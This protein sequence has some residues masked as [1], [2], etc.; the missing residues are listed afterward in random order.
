[1]TLANNDISK[2]EQIVEFP[3]EQ[4]LLYLA[5]QA[6]RSKLEELLHKEA[7]KKVSH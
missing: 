3:L 5:Y 4:C 2:F 6:D 1:M 7:L